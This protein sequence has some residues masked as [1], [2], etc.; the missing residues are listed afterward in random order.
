MKAILKGQILLSF[1]HT[2]VHLDT[3]YRSGSECYDIFNEMSPLI[4]RLLSSIRAVNLFSF[5]PLTSNA[6]QITRRR[7]RGTYEY[8]GINE[9]GA[10]IT[11][12]CTKCLSIFLL[13]T[14]RWLLHVS[15]PGNKIA[16]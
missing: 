15:K 7:A 12:L 6:Y 11:Q 4:P 13:P 14:N 8:V 3:V 2:Y 1:S 16:G 9:R 5:S 10:E